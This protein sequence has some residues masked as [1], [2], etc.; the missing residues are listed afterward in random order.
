M[1]PDYGEHTREILKEA[2]SRESEV[3]RLL[4]SGAAVASPRKG[5]AVRTASSAKGAGKWQ[6]T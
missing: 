6:A 1:P 5:L 2:G 4:Q 3:E